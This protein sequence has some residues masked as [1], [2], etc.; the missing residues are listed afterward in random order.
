VEALYRR[1]IPPSDV[2]FVGTADGF[3]RPLLH[4]SGVNFGQTYEVMAGPLNG[5]GIIKASQSALKMLWGISQA[6]RIITRQKPQTILLTGG[7]ANVPLALAATVLRVP[8][9]VYLPDIEPA[10]T[11]Q[12]LAKVA[13]KIAIT[14]PDSARF[15][16]NGQT[17][18][19]GYPLR[20]TML[21]ATREKALKHFGLDSTKPILL[22]FGGSRGAQRINIAIE[23]ILPDLLQ[24]GIQVLHITGTLDW[25][26]SHDTTLPFQKAT[27]YPMAYLH[28]DMGLAMACADL[29]VCRAGASVLGE[30]PHFGLPSI[31]VPYPHAWQY[32]KTNA[33]YIAQRGAGIR[34]D[35]GQMATNLLPTI[36]QL[37]RNRVQLETMRQNAQKL[38]QGNGAEAIAQHLTTLAGETL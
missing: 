36:R 27:Y 20:Q 17:V 34:M 7:W 21:T 10:K 18:L 35:D 14:V 32:Q 8:M 6:T 13:R 9:L 33:D 23:N 31:L 38:S 15:F 19:T 4:E 3:E 11:I 5:V 22:V 16:Q 12:F 2:S 1:G 25:Q 28:D 24:D 26:R 37:F 29:V 30:L